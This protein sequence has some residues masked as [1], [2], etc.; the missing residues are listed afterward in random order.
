[1]HNQISNGG[2]VMNERTDVLRRKDG[3][4]VHLPV[5]GVFDIVTTGSSPGGTTSTAPPS[6]MR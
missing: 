1:M 3:K 4:S 2:L 5:T 6:P